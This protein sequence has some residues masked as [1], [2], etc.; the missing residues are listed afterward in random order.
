MASTN[1]IYRETT[2]KIIAQLEKGVAPWRKPWNCGAPRMPQ[3]VVSKRAYNGVNV[4]LLWLASEH[5]GW[6]SGLFA[7]YRQWQELGGFV[8][9]GETGTKITYWNIQKKTD[10]DKTPD[11]DEAK[12]RFFLRQYTVFALDQCGGDDLDRFRTPTPVGDFAN[13]A[14][15][16]DAIAATCA[17][18]KFGG[19]RAYYSPSRDHIQLPIKSSFKDQAAYYS[20]ALHELSHWT[21]H[22]GRL[23]RLDKLARFGTQSYA[24]EELVAEMSAAFLTSALGVPNTAALTNAAAYIADWL[25]V[26]RHDS[27]AVFTASTAATKAADFILAFSGKGGSPIEEEE[28]QEA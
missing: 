16:E 17:S 20:T 8:R 28:L 24:M 15:A 1:D 2:D 7:T 22:E 5:H 26:L 21:G 6:T 23:N 4:W 25:D 14:P 10:K 19:N 18:I 9:R 27:R 13:F 11:D 3:N 12:K